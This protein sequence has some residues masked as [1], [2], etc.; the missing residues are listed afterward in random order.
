M[1]ERKSHNNTNEKRNIQ[2]PKNILLFSR[3]LR[4]FF[5]KPTNYLTNNTKSIGSKTNQNQ[6]DLVFFFGEG[7]WLLPGGRRSL[8]ALPRAL[9]PRSSPGRAA[10]GEGGAAWGLWGGLGV[11]IV[12]WLVFFLLCVCV[13]QTVFYLFFCF[14][15][16]FFEVFLEF[17][18]F[19]CFVSLFGCFASY[20]CHFLV[21]FWCFDLLVFFVACNV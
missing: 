8:R 10:G 2:H 12:F 6:L 14:L 18:V 15:L 3:I 16:C 19:W 13:F 17:G 11:Y 4:F 9:P 5:Q 21:C 1:T 20:L 7:L